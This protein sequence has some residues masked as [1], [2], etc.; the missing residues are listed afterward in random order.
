MRGLCGTS[1]ISPPECHMS[2][3]SPT[4]LGTSQAG[5]QHDRRQD[6]LPTRAY[7]GIPRVALTPAGKVRV[8]VRF[9][10]RRRHVARDS[11]FDGASRRH[12][13]AR[14]SASDRVRRRAALRTRW[15]R[16]ASSV[17]HAVVR[18]GVQPKQPAEALMPVNEA[19]N[20]PRWPEPQ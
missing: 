8:T 20:L 15:C 1:L 18:A 16:L 10:V 5:V 3:Q 6:T 2:W 4:N 7:C 14:D 17:A 19:M 12:L 13:F 11:A 9:R